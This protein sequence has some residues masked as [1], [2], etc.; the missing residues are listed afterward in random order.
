MNCLLILYLV[1]AKILSLR[2]HFEMGLQLNISA[3]VSSIPLE[4]LRSNLL[5]ETVKSLSKKFEKVTI[6]N[7]TLTS[8]KS[9]I[10]Q[11]KSTLSPK[12]VV[13]AQLHRSTT[14]EK[15]FELLKFDQHLSIQDSFIFFRL[16]RKT[17]RIFVLSGPKIIPPYETSQ[18]ISHFMSPRTKSK[19]KPKPPNPFQNH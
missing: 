15:S 7:G 18:S 9:Q 1:F 19:P 11:K 3:L 10:K 12:F 13:C 17:E 14:A 2:A 4:S 5:H 16:P 6:L 8:H